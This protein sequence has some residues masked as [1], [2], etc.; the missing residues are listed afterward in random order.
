M[1][2]LGA[3]GYWRPVTARRKTVVSLLSGVAVT[4][5]RPVAFFWKTVSEPDNPAGYWHRPLILN[6][7]AG[8]VYFPLGSD[9][10]FRPAETNQSRKDGQGWRWYRPGIE[11]LRWKVTPGRNTLRLLVSMS[12]TTSPRPGARI[13]AAPALDIPETYADA[14]ASAFTQTLIEAEVNASA[15]GVV[16]V[17]LEWLN[18]SGAGWVDW[19]DMEF[20]ASTP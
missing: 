11:R 7:R 1:S 9:G 12:D 3:I 18:F 16:V 6:G 8:Q 2:Y 17:Q 19:L 10:V 13:L 15:A 5:W 4:R 14:P 20:S